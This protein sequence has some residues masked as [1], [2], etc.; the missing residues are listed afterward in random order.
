MGLLEQGE[1]YVQSGV[2]VY[3]KIGDRAGQADS[4]LQLSRMCFWSGSFIRGTSLMTQARPIFQ[5]LGL[6]ENYTF[7]LVGEAIP[8]VLLGENQAARLRARE[9]GE[10][11]RANSFLRFHAISY[12]VLGMADL[13]DGEMH[14]AHAYLDQSVDIYRT[15][16]QN[17]ELG[18]ALAALAFADLGMG[19]TAEFLNHICESLQ[20]GGIVRGLFPLMLAIPAVALY[21]VQRSQMSPV[22]ASREGLERAVEL[23]ALTR[24]YPTAANAPWFEAAAGK[25]IAVAAASLPDAFVERA[26]ARGQ[27]GDLFAAAQELLGEFCSD[28]AK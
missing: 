16:K 9:G 20:I 17:D 4:L 13:A 5:E 8:L 6:I 1:A 11:A 14:S 15:I 28:S 21:M 7:T 26:K 12:W 19:Y 22:Q 25:T 3:E 10:V 24:R 2:T 27:A 23:Y 18:W